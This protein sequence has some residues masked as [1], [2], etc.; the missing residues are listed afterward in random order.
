MVLTWTWHD[1]FLLYMLAVNMLSTRFQSLNRTKLAD[2]RKVNILPCIRMYNDRQIQLLH[3]RSGSFC[4]IKYQKNLIM[5]H[6]LAS[7]SFWLICRAIYNSWS[8][9][10]KVIVPGWRT[11]TLLNT[12]MH[13]I[14]TSQPQYTTH[15]QLLVQ[16][17]NR[18]LHLMTR[19]L[20][21]MSQEIFHFWCY[22]E[23]LPGLLHLPGTFSV[24]HGQQACLSLHGWLFCNMTQVTCTNTSNTQAPI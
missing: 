9:L 12:P 6:V 1:T 19:R 15:H 16:W 14:Y 8:N 7:F 5:A 13:P 18:R 23:Y 11:H 24:G 10:F 21:K 3:H 20:N 2:S 22:C 4:N 17:L